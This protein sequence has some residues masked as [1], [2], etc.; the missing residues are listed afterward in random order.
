MVKSKGGLDK[1]RLEIHPHTWTIQFLFV[2]VT[3]NI[4]CK[5][6]CTNLIFLFCWKTAA[7]TAESYFGTEKR[8][9]LTFSWFS[10]CWKTAVYTPQNPMFFSVLIRAV[11]MDQSRYFHLYCLEKVW[12]HTAPCYTSL[13]W[14]VIASIQ[15]LEALDFAD[16]NSF[17]PN[18][19]RFW[20]V[21]I[22]QPNIFVLPEIWYL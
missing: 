1:N 16:E 7:H 22:L 9:S 2:M 10:C 8:L 11:N 18:G 17:P 21:C 19:T 15:F 14:P 5:D 12:Q 3:L 6:F 13:T 20:F 4:W